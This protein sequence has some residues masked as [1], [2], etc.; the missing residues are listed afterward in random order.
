MSP[1]WSQVCLIDFSPSAPCTAYLTLDLGRTSGAAVHFA[2]FTLR[3]RPDTD[4]AVREAVQPAAVQARIERVRKGD[5]TFA[6]V[7][8]STGQPLAG[9]SFERLEVE[10]VR[11]DFPFGTAVE[12]DDVPEEKLEWYLGAV[13]RHFNALVPAW[14]LKWPVGGV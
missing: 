5:L 10:L 4:T 11:H 1:T 14:S 6:F 8:G 12:W 13:A 7:N 9:V 2:D 3:A